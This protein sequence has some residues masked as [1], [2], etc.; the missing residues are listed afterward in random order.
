MRARLTVL[1]RVYALVG[2]VELG[3]SAPLGHLR[4]HSV[5]DA[6]GGSWPASYMWPLSQSLFRFGWEPRQSVPCS[7]QEFLLYLAGAINICPSV[8]GNTRT[9]L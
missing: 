8:T 6:R 3:L 9:Y 4:T 7:K 5:S 2:V 1:A